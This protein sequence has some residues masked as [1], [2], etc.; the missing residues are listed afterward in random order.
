MS[1]ERAKGALS[2]GAIHSF[3]Q[4]GRHPLLLF[5]PILVPDQEIRA[6]TAIKPVKSQCGISKIQLTVLREKTKRRSRESNDKRLMNTK[7]H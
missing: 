3:L 1:H 7:S 5:F 2:F 6:P 4:Y